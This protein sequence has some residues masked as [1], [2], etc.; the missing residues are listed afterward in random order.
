MHSYH[1]QLQTHALV[2]LTN[3]AK[4][5]ILTY[6]GVW[7]I[8]VYTFDLA[9]L[10][11]L[12]FYVNTA[13]IC[14]FCLL[15]LSHF[16]ALKKSRTPNI[17]VLNHW[18]VITILA[19]ALHWGGLAAWI[20]Y[21][22]RLS[23]LASV[24]LIITPCFALGGACTLSISS[25]IRTLYPMFMCLPYIAMLIHDGS[26]ESLMLALLSSICLTY[27]F[28]SSKATHNDYWAAITNHMVAEER[29]ELM[30]QLSTTDPLTQIKNRMFFD[31]E[32]N[33]EWKRCSRMNCPLSI[34][35]I[36]LDF[37]KNLND[38]YGHIFGDECL[39][40]AAAA[41]KSEVARPSD[42]VARYGGEEFIVLLPNTDAKGAENLAKR[43]LQ[44]VASMELE[45][46][47]QLV[48]I[49]CSIGG[50]TA[51]PDFR[52]DRANLIKAA[53]EALYHA[54]DKGRNQYYSDP[55][56]N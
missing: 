32:F 21:D 9:N 31:K 5:G 56:Q 48:N 28:T 47:S 52:K 41:I 10:H 22:D 29:A 38:N 20:I 45:A 3:R 51:T 42:C 46:D 1:S 15:R 43:M 44:A 30:E 50:A 53:D 7:L 26:S 18:L 36:D 12:F 4:S 40:Q 11:P 33:N 14:A 16:I 34:I 19:A 17:S 49:T 39:R 6:P 27:I 35:M 37:F 55:N 54:K 25:E 8:L 23:D 2:D 13:F 24:I